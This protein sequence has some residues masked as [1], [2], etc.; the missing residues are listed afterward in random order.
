MAIVT[1]TP[2]RDAAMRDSIYLV[3]I[4]VTFGIVLVYLLWRVQQLERRCTQAQVVAR[5]F[6]TVEHAHQIAQSYAQ[7][8]VVAKPPPPPPPPSS[9]PPTAASPPPSSPSPPPDSS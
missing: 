5:S 4:T 1:N 6:A 7:S 9:S 2:R 8:H 3:A